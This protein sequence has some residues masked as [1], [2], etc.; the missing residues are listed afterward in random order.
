MLKILQ[1]SLHQNVDQEFPDVQ[2]GFR[3]QRNQRSNCQHPLDHQKSKRI[4]EKHLL[5][6]HWL[7]QRLWLCGSQQTVE[8]SERNGN[9]R[10]PASWV[11]C[12]QVKKQQ[13]APDMEQPNGFKLGKKYFK[14][15]HGHFAYLTLICT[16]H[17]AKYQ[18]AQSTSWNQDSQEKINNLNKQLTTPWWQ[19]VKRNL[20]VSWQKW[21]RRV[22]KL[23]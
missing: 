22:K 23:V 9:T 21:K 11:I 2:D 4:Q 13:L 18:T 15:V 12:M 1:A 7:C 10:P 19:K 3:R 8:N 14:A 20:R 6:L 5:L 17:H 16:V